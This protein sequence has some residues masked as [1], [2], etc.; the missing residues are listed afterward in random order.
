VTQNKDKIERDFARAYHS[1]EYVEGVK[2]LEC[3][4]PGCYRRPVDAA[5]GEHSKGATGDWRFLL[6]LCS[7][8]DGHH[9]EQHSLGRRTFEAK[10]GISLEAGALETR[11]LLAHIT[12]ENG[13]DGADALSTE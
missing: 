1:A 5:H 13:L 8:L 11:K 7:G 6:P 12:G 3:Y 9:R 10:Y 2:G 4:V